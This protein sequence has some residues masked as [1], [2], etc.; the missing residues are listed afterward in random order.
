MNGKSETYFNLNII[1]HDHYQ[2]GLSS[3]FEQSYYEFKLY[4][5]EYTES[6]SYYDNY[7]S[8]DLFKVNSKLVY[9]ET[10]N[11]HLN[12]QFEIKNLIQSKYILEVS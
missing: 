11:L 6:A 5:Y 9:T 8:D 7:R 1:F 12:D 10:K 4:K 3:L 2:A